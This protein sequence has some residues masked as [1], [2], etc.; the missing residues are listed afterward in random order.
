KGVKLDYFVHWK[1][2]PI[3]ERTWEPDHHLRNSPSL[4]S[5]FHRK[6]PAA[7]RVIAAAALQ[8]RPY[9]NFTTT[10][11]KPRLFDWIT[12]RFTDCSVKILGTR[13]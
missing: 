2:Y 9:K 3:T 7:P 8:F 13:I 5:T 11:E 6:H 10:T 1:G 4:I 12:N